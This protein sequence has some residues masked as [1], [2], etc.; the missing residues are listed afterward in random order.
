MQTS[1]NDQA[2]GDQSA[3]ILNVV[4]GQAMLVRIALFNGVS[5]GSGQI[6]IAELVPPQNDSCAEP[7]QIGDGDHFWVNVLAT[8]DGSAS[9]G[10]NGNA[11]ARDLWFEYIPTEDGNA[12][13]H[14]CGSRINTILTAYSACGGAELACSDNFCVL[15]AQIDVPAVVGVPIIV[16]LAGYGNAS[17]SGYLRA[18]LRP[19]GPPNDW[20]TVPAQIAE[21]AFEFDTTFATHDGDGF[22]G[23]S[24]NAPDIWFEYMPS[25]PGCAVIE[26]CGSEL[27]TVLGVWSSCDV[28]LICNDDWCDFGSRVTVPRVEPGNPVLIRVAG[29][30]GGFGT[31]TLTVRLDPQQAFV[32]PDDYTPEPEACGTFPDMINGGCNSDPEVFGTI[33]CGE[34]IRGSTFVDNG[35]RDTDWYRFSVPVESQVVVRGQS[36]FAAIMLVLNPGCGSIEEVV[37]D[38]NTA[39]EANL[40]IDTSLSPGDYVLF[41]APNDFDVTLCPEGLTEYWISLE[42]GDNCGQ[43]LCDPDVNCDGSP[44]QGDVASMILA[45]AGDLNGFCAPDADFNLDGS[46][47]QGDVASIILVVAGGPCP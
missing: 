32:P 26:T 31:G 39:C 40:R 44:D 24:Q 8:T 45:V 21:G 42:V 6:S 15:G 13:F 27:D 23:L 18:E 10:Q 16:R 4:A 43:P 11:G 7:L 1:C 33:A 25:Q 46:A 20:C 41:I 2:C 47:D 29:Y 37:R 5:V 19:P 38:E 35:L 12:R 3:L 30:N 28:E 9:C 17:G 34:V 36:Q 22:C 14:T